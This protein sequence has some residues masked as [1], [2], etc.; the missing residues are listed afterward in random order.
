MSSLPTSTEFVLLFALRS[1]P[2]H[3]YGMLQQVTKDTQGSVTLSVATLY[4]ALARML[5]RGLIEEAGEVL[6]ERAQV[7]KQ[8]RL[9]AEGIKSVEAELNRFRHTLSLVQPQA[10][11]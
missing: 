5:E 6:N 1:E 8:Y 3:G 4:T 2:L 7:R 9:T 11:V 10:V